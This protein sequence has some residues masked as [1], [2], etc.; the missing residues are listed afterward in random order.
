MDRDPQDL[1]SFLSAR[2]TGEPGPFGTVAGDPLVAAVT[3]AIPDSRGYAAQVSE[4]HL[5][6]LSRH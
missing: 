1:I 3:A 6:L 4:C 5:W 2:G